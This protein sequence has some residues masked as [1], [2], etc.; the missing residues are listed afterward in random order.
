M[1]K[2]R[3]VTGRIAIGK[4]IG[5]VVGIVVLLLSPQFG[6]PI[7]STFGLGTLIMFVMMGVMIGFM[8]QFDRHPVLDFKMNWCMRG[9]MVGGMFMLM[10]VLLSYANIETVMQS[11]LVSWMGLESPFWALLDGIVMGIIMAYFETKY[12]G[13]GPDLPL[14]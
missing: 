1:F 2:L 7:W 11:G 6:F 13:E 14:Q 9:A 5:L 10:Y 4:M 12:A 8:G 3:S